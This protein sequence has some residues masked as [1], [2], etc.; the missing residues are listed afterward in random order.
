MGQVCSE[1]PCEVTL[2][3]GVAYTI[4]AKI[5]SR[6]SQME[7]TPSEQNTKIKIELPKKTKKDRKRPKRRDDEKGKKDQTSGSGLKIPDFFKNN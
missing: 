6:F 4:E 1:T 2:E 7:I 3:E 5:D